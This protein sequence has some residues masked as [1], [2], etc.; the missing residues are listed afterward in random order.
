MSA[1]TA[2]AFSDGAAGP[3]L[4]FAP[5]A[6]PHEVVWQDFAA[7]AEACGDFWYPEK[8]EGTS[9]VA[10]TAKRICGTCPVSAQCLNFALSRMRH[11]NDTGMFGIWAGTTVEER[12]AMLTQQ[13]APAAGEKTCTKCEITRPLAE[14][15]VRAGYRDRV[16]KKCRCARDRERL[17]ERRGAARAH[18]AV[19]TAAEAAAVLGVTEWTV[20][21]WADKGLLRAVPGSRPA[22]FASAEVTRLRD[23]RAEGRPPRVCKRPGCGK[24]V[25]AVGLCVTDYVVEWHAGRVGRA[26]RQGEA[27]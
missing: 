9:V 19:L 7:C 17:R 2:L 12:E 26:A 6:D 20:R 8:G 27:A 1:R 24:P 16:C 18:P 25:H 5:A 13:P 11:Y 14:F 4:R 3:V 23:K 10:K 15:Y 21:R 22:R